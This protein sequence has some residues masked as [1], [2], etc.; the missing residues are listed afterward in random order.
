[1]LNTNKPQIVCYTTKYYKSNTTKATDI[2]AILAKNKP[3]ECKEIC[4]NVM[5]T[6]G[7]VPIFHIFPQPYEV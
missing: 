6:N 7:V 5:G 2:D 4:Q 1:M 3:Q